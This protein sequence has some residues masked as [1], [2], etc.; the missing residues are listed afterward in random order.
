MM[1]FVFVIILIPTA[2]A[3]FTMELA[4]RFPYLAERSL[5]RDAER[6]PLGW[7]DRYRDEWLAELDLKRSRGTDLPKFGSEDRIAWYVRRAPLAELVGRK[8]PGRDFSGFNSSPNLVV[9][10]IRDPRHGFLEVLQP[11]VCSTFAGGTRANGGTGFNAC[12]T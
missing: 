9:E 3:L 12:S 7:S 10:S 5:R 2:I 4:G 11:S 1:E 6:L 8:R